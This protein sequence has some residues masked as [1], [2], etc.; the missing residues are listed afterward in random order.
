MLTEIKQYPMSIDEIVGLYRAGLIS[1]A[2]ARELLVKYKIAP[3]DVL[4]NKTVE[5]D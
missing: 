5:R 2:E 3:G 4:K 1:N